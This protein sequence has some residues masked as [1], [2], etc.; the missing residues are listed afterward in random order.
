VEVRDNR[1]DLHRLAMLA[2]L[3]QGNSPSPDVVPPNPTMLILGT[4][5]VSGVVF[6]LRKCPEMMEKGLG[7]R[8]SVAIRIA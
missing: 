6:C 5:T 8:I 1:Q 3:R 4:I 7:F 2:T